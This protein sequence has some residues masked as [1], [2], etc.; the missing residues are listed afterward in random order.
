MHQSPPVD[1]LAVGMETDEA[2]LQCHTEF[3]GRIAEHTHHPVESAGSRCYNCHMPF[4]TYG[5]LKSVR[6][7]LIDSPPIAFASGG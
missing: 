6:S 5:L 1:Q 7:H 3:R 4:T 2:C